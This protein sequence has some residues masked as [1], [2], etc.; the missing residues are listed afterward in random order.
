MM[1]EEEN[2]TD[3]VY[4]NHCKT[5]CW[6]N[7]TCCRGKTKKNTESRDEGLFVRLLMLDQMKNKNN[8]QEPNNDTVDNVSVM[9]EPAV[10]QPS[11]HLIQKKTKEMK[12]NGKNVG[13]TILHF[14]SH[15][16]LLML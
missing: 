8:Q 14:Y 15:L 2:S 6:M 1:V 10:K 9:S 7:E 3:S 13:P 4:C 12:R 16:L 11:P 5:K